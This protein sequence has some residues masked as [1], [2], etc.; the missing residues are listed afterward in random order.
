MVGVAPQPRSRRTDRVRGR[1]L[2]ERGLFDVLG[3]PAL[4][5]RTF[6]ADDDR[7]GGGSQGPVTVIGYNFWQRRFAGAADAIGR[8]ITIERVPFTIIGVMPPEFF[9][10]DVGRAIDVVIP[11]G[12]E[13]LVRGKESWLDR[14]S[15]WWLSVMVRI[16]PDAGHAHGDG[17]AASRPAAGP[18]SHDPRQLACGGQGR[19][20]QGAVCAHPVGDRQLGPP[21]SLSASP[22]DDHGGCRPRV[23]D[24]VCEH[25]EP[26]ARARQRSATRD[27]RPFC[28]WRI[29][30]AADATAALGESAALRVWSAARTDLRAVGQPPSR[31]PVLHA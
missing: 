2:G 14:R 9:G 8:S 30:P 29:P 12:T 25:R 6:T 16:K 13:P 31:P 19:V 20:P 4:L 23:T 27:Q 21:F 15:T 5:G 22:D 24:R 3:V 1:R 17:G 28:A 26:P 10:T 7:R 11:I 18:R